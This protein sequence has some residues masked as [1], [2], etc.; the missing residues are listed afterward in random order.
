MAQQTLQ[1]S[2]RQLFQRQQSTEPPLLGYMSLGMLNQHHKNGNILIKKLYITQKDMNR[3]RV[4][5]SKANIQHVLFHNVSSINVRFGSKQM[6]DVTV[7]GLCGDVII[8][9]LST[10]KLTFKQ[11]V[12]NNLKIKANIKKLHIKEC[13]IKGDIQFPTF[14]PELYVDM[15]RVMK[16]STIGCLDLRYLQHTRVIHISR[17]DCKLVLP[18]QVDTLHTLRIEHCSTRQN[19]FQDTAA[20]LRLKLGFPALTK[21]WLMDDNEEQ[22]AK[23]HLFA[24]M[25]KL[26]FLGISKNLSNVA[27]QGRIHEFKEFSDQPEMGHPQFS[28]IKRLITLEAQAATMIPNPDPI[29]QDG[30]DESYQRSKLFKELFDESDDSSEESSP[31]SNA[32]S[33]SSI[34]WN[35]PVRMGKSAQSRSVRSTSAPPKR[36]PLRRTIKGHSN[37]RATRPLR[38][39]TLPAPSLTEL[40]G[41]VHNAVQ[42]NRQLF[43]QLA[44]R[45]ARMAAQNMALQ[46][47]DPRPQRREQRPTQRPREVIVIDSDDDEKK[48]VYTAVPYPP[49]PPFQPSFQV[50]FQSR[51]KP[52]FSGP[53]QPVVIEIDTDDEDGDHLPLRM[54]TS[55]LKRNGSM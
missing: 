9:D 20:Y 29:E 37:R 24:D 5:L 4:D 8:P 46:P 7:S 39:E 1:Q 12:T 2:Q 51:Q 31:S 52:V 53:R 34:N 25:P 6:L 18:Q 17:L 38:H 21:L 54:F 45:A 10:K 55:V 32:S 35:N 23:L 11:A 42:Q 50:P 43:R 13:I 14:T 30:S 28:E 15:L 41:S 22:T 26:E 16:G 36:S 27:L 3:E 40:R 47:N 48:Q 33:N 44:E 19:I 49:F